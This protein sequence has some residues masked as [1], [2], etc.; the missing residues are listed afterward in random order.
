MLPYPAIYMGA[1]DMNPGLQACVA[2]EPSLQPLLL[3]VLNVSREASS[4]ADLQT[5]TLARNEPRQNTLFPDLVRAPGLDLGIAVLL[6][7]V[8]PHL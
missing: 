3:L 1:A 7:H 6:Y 2:T 5:C 8:Q 4:L